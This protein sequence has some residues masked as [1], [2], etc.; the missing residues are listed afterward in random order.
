M[1]PLN[2]P[3]FRMGGPI[4]EG[5][6][7]GIEEPR[8]AYQDGAFGTS[9]YTEDDYRDFINRVFV[10]PPPSET[11][12]PGMF[13]PEV[14]NFFQDGMVTDQYSYENLFKPGK[15]IFDN[16]L[17]DYAKAGIEGEKANR[18]LT[19]G[20]TGFATALKKDILSKLPKMDTPKGGGA[21]F[22]AEEITE[23]DI[24]D[25]PTYI[26]KMQ[27]GV[28]QRGIPEEKKDSETKKA[29]E[30]DFASGKY[31]TKSEP[32]GDSELL[33]KL[34][35]DRAVKRGNYQ[36]IEAIRRGLTEGGVQG[37]LDAA[38]AAGA[39]DPYGEASKIRQAAAL[40]EFEQ[41]QEQ[42]KYETRRRDKLEDTKELAEFTAKINKKYKNST[43]QSI[44]EKRY[45]FGKSIGLTG[46]DLDIFTRGAKTIDENILIA[47]TKSTYGTLNNQTLFTAVAAGVGADKV[48]NIDKDDRFSSLKDIPDDFGVGNY[49]I[50][51]TKLYVVKED[52]DGKK[53]L[54]FQANYG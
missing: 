10:K 52:A 27:E 9:A 28:L 53:G 51:G 47:Q 20:K 12:I 8:R 43:G 37:A 1:R 14:K 30:E 5:I 26:A 42:K 25:N 34:G 7:D 4:K 31:K 45:N 38:F 22:A 35:Y 33:K 16:P 6:M 18:I 54:Q 17:F 29:K 49:V 13:R 15:S 3:M 46:N 2:R 48:I 44:E 24:E 32:E 41:E 19:G 21:A 23:G 39:T 40:K 50:T 11:T 36:L